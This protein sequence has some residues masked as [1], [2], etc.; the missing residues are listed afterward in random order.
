MQS[1]LPPG[2]KFAIFDSTRG[3]REVPGQI[4]S[5]DAFLTTEAGSKENRAGLLVSS[6]D[7]MP[8][9]PR[10]FFHGRFLFG[11]LF[12]ADGPASSLRIIAGWSSW[13]ARQAHNLEAAAFKSCPRYQLSSRMR[14][15][16]RIPG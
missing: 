1:G 9:H 5:S 8:V 10:R 7:L 2:Q 14:K 6:L 15:A 11:L 3:T 12:D 16:N 13:L 4:D